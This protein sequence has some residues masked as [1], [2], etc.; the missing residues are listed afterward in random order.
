M[1]NN[2]GILGWCILALIIGIIFGLFFYGLES[3]FDLGF[4]NNPDLITFAILTLM[5]LSIIIKIKEI[6]KHLKNNEQAKAKMLNEIKLIIIGILGGLIIGLIYY[7]IS[8]YF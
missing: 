4:E 8:K 5:V 2:F 3:L 7:L 1:K 6:Y